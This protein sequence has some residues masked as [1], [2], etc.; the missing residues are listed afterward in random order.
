[1]LVTLFGVAN[2]QDISDLKQKQ[3]EIL[4][5]IDDLNQLIEEKKSE[6]INLE[7]QIAIFDAKINQLDLQIQETELEIEQVTYEI[8]VLTKEIGRQQRMLDYQKEILD[9]SIQI[10]YE[11][12]DQNLLMILLSAQNFSDFIDQV[13]YIEAIKDQVKTT[14]TE[15]NRLKSNLE[16]QRGELN[17]QKDELEDL[18]ARKDQEQTA[19]EEQRNAKELLLDQTRGEEQLFQEQLNEAIAEENAVGAEIDRLIEQ[20]KQKLA[21]QYP[22]LG[23]GDGFGYPLAG[24]NRIS[25]IG[26]DFMDPYY[27]FGFPHYGID[28]YAPQGTPVYAASSGVVVVAH[29]S[30]GP[31]LSY[32]AIQHGGGYLTKYLHMSEVFVAGGQYVSRGEV[33]GLSGGSPGTRGAGYFTTGP[34]LHFEIR[35]EYGNA[36]NP[37]NILD[38]GP[39][40]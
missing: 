12:G 18:K 36:I 1:M 39:P 26:G 14:I 9:E 13:T 31:G 33:I 16:Q 20:A 2:S 29:D 22:D 3:E 27:G 23:G 21:D 5:E 19:L 10:L 28:L 4:D 40:Y 38:F 24:Y 15:I 32:I 7:S 35:D 25:V 11:R 37:N 6:A 34:H 8:D 30:G 17:Q